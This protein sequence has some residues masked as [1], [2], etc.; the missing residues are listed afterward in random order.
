M[1]E[2]SKQSK[3]TSKKI[4][5]LLLKTKN[6]WKNSTRPDVLKTHNTSIIWL[7]VKTL[8]NYSESW[9]KQSTISN[10]ANS[11]NWAATT[12]LKISSPTYNFS[13]KLTNL[14]TIESSYNS[15]PE[16]RDLI[17]MTPN[18]LLS[19]TLMSS[20]IQA[21]QNTKMSEESKKGNKTPSILITKKD[22]SN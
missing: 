16:Q 1:Q 9:R 11:Y 12:T 21:T 15:N 18:I 20:I 19:Q 22:K 2:K 3:T 6:Y 17:K 8:L 4:K 5:I 10:L 14:S 7:I 13:T